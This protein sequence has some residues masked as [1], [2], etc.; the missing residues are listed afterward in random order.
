MMKDFAGL[1]RSLLNLVK[2][3]NRNRTREGLGKDFPN[4]RTSEQD[5]RPSTKE[6]RER[7]QP[8]EGLVDEGLQGLPLRIS[9]R[10]AYW[11]MKKFSVNW[12]D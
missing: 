4:W 6:P 3:R 7:A 10:M 12:E 8:P 11:K 1:T 5:L 2:P 9:L